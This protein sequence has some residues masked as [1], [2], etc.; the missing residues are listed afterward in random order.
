MITR[1]TQ[2]S[3]RFQQA[4]ISDSA[5]PAGQTQRHLKCSR[6]VA[7]L[8]KN[9]ELLAGQQDNVLSAFEHYSG[10]TEHITFCCPLRQS[11][12]ASPFDVFRV[13]ERVTESPWTANISDLVS[14][15]WSLRQL[16]NLWCCLRGSVNASWSLRE[17][18]TFL[19]ERERLW[20]P[21]P[22]SSPSSS[23]AAFSVLTLPGP[24]VDRRYTHPVEDL[25]TETDPGPQLAD[26]SG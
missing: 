7:R 5:P 24:Y 9:V 20:L 25:R 14:V 4:F 10:V 1:Y 8:L 21:A 6:Q 19:V 18:W 12:D 2:Y 17:Q 11:A 3:V 23:W 26:I 15:F 22:T 16:F 13:K